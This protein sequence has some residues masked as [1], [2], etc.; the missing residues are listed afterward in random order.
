MDLFEIV[1]QG[2]TITKGIEFGGNRPKHEEIRGEKGSKTSI[3]EV[4]IQLLE[5]K[6]ISL[7]LNH[8]YTRC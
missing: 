5:F 8:T 7:K 1:P 2:S 3:F 6:C 4:S